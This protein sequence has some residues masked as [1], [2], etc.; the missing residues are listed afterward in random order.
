MTFNLIPLDSTKVR[1]GFTIDAEAIFSKLGAKDTSFFDRKPGQLSFNFFGVTPGMLRKTAGERSREAMNLVSS[2]LLEFNLHRELLGRV[3]DCCKSELDN[4][5]CSEDESSER[6]ESL[7][8]YMTE[9]CSIMYRH[10]DNPVVVVDSGDLS[11]GGNVLLRS[12][13]F[14]DA[15]KIASSEGELK[16]KL[17]ESFDNYMTTETVSIR[18]RFEL[19][20]KTVSSM[21][22]ACEE[23]S[24]ENQ[25]RAR[26]LRTKF[27]QTWQFMLKTVESSQSSKG[28]GK[29]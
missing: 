19:L 15:Q 21:M 25:R 14:K 26:E 17:Q 3:N 7:E 18:Q 6:L 28:K 20:Q 1:S 8:K 9:W 4:P 12:S 24:V 29:L 10:L 23:T 11:V 16:T 22:S 5:S 2:S 27:Q 13:D